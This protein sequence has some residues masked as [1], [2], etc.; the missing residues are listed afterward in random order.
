MGEK[1][2]KE[3][4]CFFLYMH[5]LKELDMEES[6]VLPVCLC[7]KMWHCNKLP[8]FIKQYDLGIFIVPGVQ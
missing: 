1:R 5:V 6:A 3:C 4:V 7:A 8:C 2:E